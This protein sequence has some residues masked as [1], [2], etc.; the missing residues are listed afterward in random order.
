MD[1]PNCDGSGP[2][3]GPTVRRVPHFEGSD[4]A[5]ILCSA[6][7]YLNNPNRSDKPWEAFP[8]YGDTSPSFPTAG[9]YADRIRERLGE[10]KVAE[11]LAHLPK[12]TMI[13]SYDVHRTRT[14]TTFYGLRVFYRGTTGLPHSFAYGLAADCLGGAPILADQTFYLGKDVAEA[15]GATFK[16]AQYWQGWHGDLHPARAVALLGEVLYG[17]SDAFSHRRIA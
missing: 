10:A 9:S 15:L 14:G 3:T 1:N 16:L 7:F 12:G 4:G 6:C 13:W 2:H 5:D 17:T 8:V 11:L